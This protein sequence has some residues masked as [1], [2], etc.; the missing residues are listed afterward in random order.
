M[1]IKE[2]KQNKN[3]D[4]ITNVSNF[5]FFLLKAKLILVIPP[6]QSTWMP[7]DKLTKQIKFW[8]LSF[9]SPRVGSS[10]IYRLKA[11]SNKPDIRDHL[12]RNIKEAGVHSLVQEALQM[13]KYRREPNRCSSQSAQTFQ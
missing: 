11:Q 8:V 4:K 6:F 1:D 3:T 12:P 10:S 9:P 5:A 7:E 2:F 13:L